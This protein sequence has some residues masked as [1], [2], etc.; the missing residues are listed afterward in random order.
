MSILQDIQAKAINPETNITNLLRM[1]MILAVRLRNEELRK[2]VSQELNG[3]EPS[4]DLPDYRIVKCSSFGT[5][6]DGYAVW[7]NLGI[8]TFNVPENFHSYIHTQYFRQGI[9]VLSYMVSHAEEGSI[10]FGW[11]KMAA[12]I[13]AKYN[14]PESECLEAYRLVSVSVI[15]AI[16]DTVKTR[17]LEFALEIEKEDP[18]AGETS[19]EMPRITA[20]R[21]TNIFNT[22]IMANHAGSFEQGRSNMSE[23]P[24]F[25][26]G[27]QQAGRDLIQA[28][29]DIYQA[30]GD[31]AI[32]S[33]SPAADVLKV[34]EAIKYKID[35]LD[36]DEK[37]KKKIYNHLDN[38][39]VELED[40]N[41]DKRSIADSMKQTNEILKEA[42]TSG[43]TLNDIGALISKVVVW[44]GPFA[45]SI[46]LI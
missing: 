46:G 24:I 10:K 38:A 6:T 40:K 16:I 11:E 17:I 45:H 25:N 21:S 31:I 9:E 27:S 37:N 15:A 18:N 22:T 30:A 5:F 7:N 39:V 44:L 12:F 36:I 8:S 28:G 13:I 4:T 1:C 29:R 23:G 2:W 3:Y 33:S 14:Y 34:M 42:K 41:P 20:E 32:S 35:E 26:I 19:G 43:E